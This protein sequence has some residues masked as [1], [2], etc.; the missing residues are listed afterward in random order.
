MGYLID[1]TNRRHPIEVPAE[2]DFAPCML[3][4]TNRRKG[5]HT[6]VRYTVDGVQYKKSIPVSSRGMLKQT[7]WYNPNN[8]SDCISSQS[9]IMVYVLY[10]FGGLFLLVSP[11]IAFYI[12]PVQTT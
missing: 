7:V 9:K 3:I 4:E 8:P 6:T 12:K 10:T 1:W 2:Y 11:L 5:C